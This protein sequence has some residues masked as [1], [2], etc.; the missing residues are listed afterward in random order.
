MGKVEAT[1]H[2]RVRNVK[3]VL[4]CYHEGVESARGKRRGDRKELKCQSKRHGVVMP[5]FRC[6]NRMQTGYFGRTM[7]VM[8]ADVEGLVCAALDLGR[9]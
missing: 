2:E 6:I 8:G 1:N 9:V 3:R 7:G 4:Q 5:M